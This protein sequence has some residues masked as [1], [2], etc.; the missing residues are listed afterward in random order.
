MLPAEAPMFRRMSGSKAQY[1]YLTLFVISEFNEWRVLLQGPET[2]IQGTRQFTEEKARR[3]ALDV[4][5]SYV[6]D[7]RHEDLPEPPEPEWVP[8]AA[9]S[10]LVWS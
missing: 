4:A 1:H 9:D 10:W 8:C 6:H 5:R 3:H 2:V 7:Q